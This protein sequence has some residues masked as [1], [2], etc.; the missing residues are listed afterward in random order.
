MS[1]YDTIANIVK[2]ITRERQLDQRYGDLDV[3]T[4]ER[5]QHQAEADGTK[6]EAIWTGV[7]AV[8]VENLAEEAESERAQAIAL[9]ARR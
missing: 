4:Q 9:S 2:N 3:Q 6:P 5:I 7:L 1:S 8:R